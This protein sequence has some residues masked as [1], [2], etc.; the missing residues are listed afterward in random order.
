MPAPPVRRDGDIADPDTFDA[1]CAGIDHDRTLA[2]ADTHDLERKTRDDRLLIG[3]SESEPPHDA[4]G[5]RLGRDSPGAPS[6]RAEIRLVLHQGF[7]VLQ[8]R[9]RIF[10][11]LADR[12][13]VNRA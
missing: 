2:T 1:L 13:G 6:N 7:V 11:R 8:E 12:G 5:I 3:H 9:H 10:S 4:V